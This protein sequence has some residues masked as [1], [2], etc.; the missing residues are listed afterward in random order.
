MPATR[1]VATTFR[2]F[3]SFPQRYMEPCTALPVES[4]AGVR[5]EPL[6][7]AL[8]PTLYTESDLLVRQFTNAAARRLVREPFSLQQIA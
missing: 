6:K 8:Q 1:R 7:R 2:N 3:P 4:P 5:V